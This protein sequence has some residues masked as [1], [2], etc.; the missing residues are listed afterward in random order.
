ML[1]EVLACSSW[2]QS[3]KLILVTKLR[4]PALAVLLALNLAYLWTACVVNATVVT[5]Q[6][7]QKWNASL[8]GGVLC[9]TEAGIEQYERFRD[10]REGEV[11]GVGNSASVKVYLLVSWI[12]YCNCL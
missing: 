7:T 12:D 6:A 8:A 4:I 2:E 11:A 9:K 5:A 3:R 1:S 10:V